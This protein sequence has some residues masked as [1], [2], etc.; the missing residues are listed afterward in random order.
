MRWR[1][2]LTLAV[3][4]IASSCGIDSGQDPGTQP[5][6]TVLGTSVGSDQPAPTLGSAVSTARE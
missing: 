6:V 4:L 2:I 5:D 1:S 3:L